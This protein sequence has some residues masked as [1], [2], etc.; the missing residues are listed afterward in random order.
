MPDPD[1][2]PDLPTVSAT[3]APTIPWDQLELNIHEVRPGSAIWQVHVHE[4][5]DDLLDDEPRWST[6]M[7][8]FDDAA[9]AE[10]SFN[11]GGLDT[12]EGATGRLSQEYRESIVGYLEHVTGMRTTG[13][14][15]DIVDA[16]AS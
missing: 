1:P 13:L 7:M 16:A 5:I 15:H 11:A 9:F 8:L 12:G 2:D 10:H 14:V 6:R 3:N 4:L